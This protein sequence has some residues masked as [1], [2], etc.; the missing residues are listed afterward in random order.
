MNFEGCLAKLIFDQL[1]LLIDAF[2]PNFP[3]PPNVARWCLLSDKVTNKLII[4][5]GVARDEAPR[6]R[7]RNF[8]VMDQSRAEVTGAGG[9][10]CPC[11]GQRRA[12]AHL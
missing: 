6:G 2:H 4:C 7:L 8:P 3:V 1:F 10:L 9:N 12:G 11:Q 5:P